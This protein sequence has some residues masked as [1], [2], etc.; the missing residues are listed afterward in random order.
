MASWHNRNLA[1]SSGDMCY[2]ALVG[3]LPFSTLALVSKTAVLRWEETNEAWSTEPHLGTFSLDLTSG[4]RDYKQMHE[5]AI[6]SRVWPVYLRDSIN[7]SSH[8]ALEYTHTLHEMSKKQ[9]TFMQSWNNYHHRN[10]GET[11]QRTSSRLASN[12][13]WFIV[14]QNDDDSNSKASTDLGTREYS[15]GKGTE[16][17]KTDTIFYET[18]GFLFWVMMK[19][20]LV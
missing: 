3:R 10:L 2:D 11:C 7:S 17:L 8:L 4:L 5:A 9:N 6:R 12:I 15:A 18:W 13:T 16:G 19:P 1:A 14:T 20:S